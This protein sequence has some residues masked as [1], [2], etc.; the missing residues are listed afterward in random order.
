MGH[1]SSTID[2]GL[3]MKSAGAAKLIWTRLDLRR[4]LSVPARRGAAKAVLRLKEFSFISLQDRSLSAVV[5]RL[6]CRVEPVFPH[7]NIS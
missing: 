3:E 4:E 5:S 1:P 2:R 6:T 7:H